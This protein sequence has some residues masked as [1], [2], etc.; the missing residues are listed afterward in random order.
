MMALGMF[1]LLLPFALAGIRVG[2]RI[3]ARVSRAQ[4]LRVASVLLM[5]IGVSLLVRATNQ[6]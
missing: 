3:S 6:I 5:L 4:L 1:L 2:T